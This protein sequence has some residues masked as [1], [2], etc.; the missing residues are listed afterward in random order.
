MAN[1]LIAL[2]LAVAMVLCWGSTVAA[3]V[4]PMLCWGTVEVDGAQAPGGTIIEIYIGDSLGGSFIVTTPG[5]YGAVVVSG[6]DQLYGMDLVYKVNGVVAQK[7]GPDPGV[8]GLE[9]QVVG[10]VVSACPAS[11]IWEFTGPGYTPR[12]LPDAYF[13]EVVLVDLDDVPTQIQGVYK[14]DDDA[15]VWLFWAPNAPGCTLTALEGGTVADY[16][17]TTVDACQWEIELN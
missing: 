10:L 12:H 1:K 8:F 14:F 17:V 7:N 11:K 16:M 3:D 6:D 4:T 5:R 15:L 13:G 9:N 2:V